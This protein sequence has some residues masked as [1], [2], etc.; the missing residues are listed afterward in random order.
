M[1]RK[2]ILALR[3]ADDGSPFGQWLEASEQW[4]V[5]LHPPHNLRHAGLSARLTIFR[6][7]KAI[8]R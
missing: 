6:Y 8:S 3:R 7:V 2:F 4:S 1:Y 5:E